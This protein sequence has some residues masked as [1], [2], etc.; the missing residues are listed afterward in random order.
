MS[1]GSATARTA[2]PLRVL[3]CPTLVGSNPS[4]LARSERKLGLA[5][6]AVAF[7]QNYIN[8]DCDE[9]LWRAGDGV[10]AREFKRWKL[11]YRALSSFDV[12]HFNFGRSILPESIDPEPG[13][14]SRLRGVLRRAY[15]LYGLLFTLRDL[16]LLKRAGKAIFVTYQGSDARQI[17]YCRRHFEIHFADEVPPGHFPAGADARKR[18]EIGVF[19]RYANGIFSLNPDLLHVLPARAQFVPYASVDPG[20]WRPA[21][22]RPGTRARPL[23]AHAPTNREIKGTRFLMD[24][25]GRLKSEGIDFELV[26]VENMPRAEARAIYERAD[27]VVDQL[28]AGWYGGMA[29]EAMALGK[30]VVCYLR[31]D[32]LR[33]LP[34]GMRAELPILE[35]TPGTVYETLRELLGPRRHTLAAAGANSRSYVERWHDPDAVAARMK[36]CYLAA[37][38]GASKAQRSPA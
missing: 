38:P 15:R 33:F 3:H 28:L 27:L 18:E 24:A 25:L 5:S 36:D 21:G 11:L 14:A 35:A 32:D 7:E 34:P 37:L 29:V 12:V 30:P 26:L 16:P 31:H 23:L 8:D 1:T 10:A 22:Y 19:D 20:E 2:E 9:V 6:W 17:D 4:Q 13:T